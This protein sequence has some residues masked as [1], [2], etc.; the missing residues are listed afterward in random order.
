[1]VVEEDAKDTVKVKC[2][3]DFPFENSKCLGSQ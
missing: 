3:T 2:P 1:M